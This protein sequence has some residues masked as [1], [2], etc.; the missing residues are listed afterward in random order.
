MEVSGSYNVKAD[1]S[2]MRLLTSRASKMRDK[3][4]QDICFKGLGEIRESK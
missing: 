4:W 3:G 2:L 1:G